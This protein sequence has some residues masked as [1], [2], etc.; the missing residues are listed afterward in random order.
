MS[1]SSTPGGVKPGSAQTGPAGPAIPPAHPGQ[2]AEPTESPHAG[3][4]PNHADSQHA[5]PWRKWV[6]WAGAA[7]GVAAAAY[8]LIPWIILALNTVSTDDAYVNGHVTFVAAPGA[9]PGDQGPG[10]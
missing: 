6:I 4:P 8:F 3:T 1:F 2:V 9:G 5:P 10:G 7:V